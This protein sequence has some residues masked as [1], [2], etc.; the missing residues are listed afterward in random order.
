MRCLAST[1][2]VT[3]AGASFATG[4]PLRRVALAPTPGP[5]ATVDRFFGVGL[6]ARTLLGRAAPGPR[7]GAVAYAQVQPELQ[8]VLPLEDS[9][10]VG[11]RGAMASG[12]LWPAP[13]G[14]GRLRGDAASW[15]VSGSLGCDL[16]DDRGLTLAAQVGLAFI[17]VVEAQPWVEPLLVGGGAAGWHHTLGP[18]RLLGVVMVNT[19][20]GSR[21]DDELPESCVPGINCQ[22]SAHRSPWSTFAVTTVSLLA[23]ATW[24]VHPHMAVKAELWVPLVAPTSRM[25][26]SVMLALVVGRFSGP[27]AGGRPGPD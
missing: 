17:T 16:G 9:C 13:D 2:L 6:G 22:P 26:P 3:V 27:R 12:W 19:G 24:Q 20:V 5:P 21:F 25:P 18:V 1:L 7:L 4:V 14:L 10:R 23:G 8:L 11:L 15:E